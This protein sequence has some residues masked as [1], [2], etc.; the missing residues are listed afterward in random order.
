MKIRK[1]IVLILLF[2]LLLVAFASGM[3]QTPAQGDQKKKAEA[4]CSMESCCCKDDS[5]PMKEE[6]AAKADAKDGCCGS[7]DSCEMKAKHDLKDHGA[8]GDCCNMKHKDSKSKARQ[9]SA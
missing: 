6:G 4:C 8:K 7:G 5:C 2:G 1:N 3:A 9:K